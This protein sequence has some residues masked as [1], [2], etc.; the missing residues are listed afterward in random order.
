MSV[1]TFKK[2]NLEVN[3]TEFFSWFNNNCF[4]R[5]YHIP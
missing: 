1:E 4:Y 5:S 2:M 3:V